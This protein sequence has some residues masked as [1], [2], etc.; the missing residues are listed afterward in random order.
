MWRGGGP[1][2]RGGFIVSGVGVGG[3]SNNNKKMKPWK[4]IKRIV[5]TI[6]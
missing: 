5:P 2:V 4:K 3:V 6:A 1:R